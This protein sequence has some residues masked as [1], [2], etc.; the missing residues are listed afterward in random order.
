MIEIATRDT[1]DFP[2]VVLDAPYLAQGVTKMYQ[3]GGKKL[4]PCRL[5]L[6]SNFPAV[7]T[8]NGRASVREY[9]MVSSSK[10]V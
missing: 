4:M 3:D 1:S 10:L 8:L 7:L 5:R 9:T 6:N 2:Q